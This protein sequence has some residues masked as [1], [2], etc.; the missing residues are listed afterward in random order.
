M[1]GGVILVAAGWSVI[2]ASVVGAVLTVALVLFFELKSRREETLLAERSP[3][4]GAYRDRTRRRFLPWL[5]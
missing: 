2:F 3:D 5:Y 4:Y 1:Y